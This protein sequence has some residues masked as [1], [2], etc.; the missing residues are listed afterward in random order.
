MIR[1]SAK[2]S[3][4]TVN[5]VSGKDEEQQRPD[6]ATGISELAIDQC[7]RTFEINLLYFAT[8]CSP[9]IGREQEQQDARVEQ[10]DLTPE[11]YEE[12]IKRGPDQI[13]EF[14]ILPRVNLE[15]IQPAAPT[16]HEDHRRPAEADQH[17]IGPG[18][19]CGRVGGVAGIGSGLPGK[20]QVNRVLGQ[21]PDQRQAPIAP[22]TVEYLV[23]RSRRTT[24][25]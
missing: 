11:R 10:A 8:H 1:L 9:H 18:H 15:M 25:T 19:V 7:G 21:N 16:S 23:R 6:P 24:P 13:A 3:A 4:E 17:A 14:E 22:W 5:G 20:V 2:G 12:R